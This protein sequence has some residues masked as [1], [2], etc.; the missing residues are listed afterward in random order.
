MARSDKTRAIAKSQA[1][2]SRS[3]VKGTRSNKDQIN[4]SLASIKNTM[5]A[6]RQKAKEDAQNTNSNNKARK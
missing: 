2:L 3:K 6:N 5:L 1:R 4:L